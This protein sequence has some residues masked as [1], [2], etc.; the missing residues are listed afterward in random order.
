MQ[1]C[2]QGITTE[3]FFEEKKLS[4]IDDRELFILTL[5][6]LKKGLGLVDA[7]KYSFLAFA[8]NHLLVPLK[9]I[10]Y[11][12]G[13]FSREMNHE[14]NALKEE[15]LLKIEKE[16]VIDFY[17]KEIK[18]TPKGERKI[19]ENSRKIK[20]I[21]DKLKKTIEV[22]SDY[23][24][25]ALVRHCYDDFLLR[26]KGNNISSWETQR[27]SEISQ[28]RMLNGVL[29]NYF[30]NLEIDENKKI[31]ICTSLDYTNKL[32]DDSLL[33]QID[34][35]ISGTILRN[36]RVYLE[37]WN[38]ISILLKEEENCEVKVRNLLKENQKIFSFLN[39]LSEEYNIKESVFSEIPCI[40]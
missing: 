26:K 16:R 11:H 21:S 7:Y 30:D 28:L 31:L 37:N 32:L 13:P 14:I 35:V 20:Q 19:K 38:Q 27:K 15:G 17:K 22:Y 40:V 29:I 25:T 33:N 6:Q 18:L 36:I 5:A 4:K 1:N 9:F 3:E 8:E 39:E 24:A 23:T 2:M 10:K 34:E 12:Y